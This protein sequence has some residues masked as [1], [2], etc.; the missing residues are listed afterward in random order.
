MPL[1]AHLTAAGVRPQTHA[2]DGQALLLDE[3][4]LVGPPDGFFHRCQEEGALAGAE[5]VEHGAADA[6]ARAQQ[7]QRQVRLQRMRQLRALVH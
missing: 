7:P 5:A 2:I 3:A 6:V 1:H 4:F